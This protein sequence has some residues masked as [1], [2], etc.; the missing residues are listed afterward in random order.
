MRVQCENKTQ[1]RWYVTRFA[2]G[3]LVYNIC[4]QITFHLFFQVVAFTAAAA[5]AV[6]VSGVAVVVMFQHPPDQERR[7]RSFYS[8]I[9]FFLVSVDLNVGANF[10]RMPFHC[11]VLY[12][13]N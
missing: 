7:L 8:F 6:V 9:S 3:N 10:I 5:A 2:D 1:R 12:S 4:F 11:R 13:I